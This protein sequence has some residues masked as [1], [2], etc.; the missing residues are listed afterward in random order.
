MA[1][2]VLTKEIAYEALQNFFANNKPLV[3]FGTGTSC[4]IDTDFGMEPLFKKLSDEIPKQTS[5]KTMIS[6]WRSVEENFLSTK[7]FEN[8]MNAIKNDK[9][10]E[11]IVQ[12]TFKHVKEVDQ[13]ACNSIFN[14]D[15]T[16]TAIS[17]LKKIVDNLPPVDPVLHVATPNYDM[18]AEY[19]FS[20]ANIPYITGF[21][22]GIV[23]KI[24]WAQASRT[25]TFSEIISDRGKTQFTTRK[26]NHIRL[27]KVHGSLNTFLMNGKIVECDIWK[28]YTPDFVK[29]MIITPGESKH[30]K[31]HNFRSDLLKEFD[32]A[33]NNHNA[34]LFLGFGFNDTQLINDKIKPKLKEQKPALI[35]TRDLNKNIQELLNVSE[36]CWIVC[37]HQDSANE[38]TRIYN[39]KFDNWLYINDQQLWN[40]KT[41]TTVILGG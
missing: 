19:A 33:V 28:D 11:L 29:P 37:K 9:L 12:E 34:F 31:I 6:E 3:L 36:N 15:K 25:I 16:W 22:G 23:K 38:Y 32:D 4:A 5:D 8:A 14:E 13:K 30:Q 7:D 39:S 17:L 1:K 24:D 40:F 18:V 27:Y 20:V 21:W 26:K 35:I 10:L 2:T 41:F